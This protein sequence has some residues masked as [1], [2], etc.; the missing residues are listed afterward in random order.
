NP[1]ASGSSS[2]APT[3][4]PS[5]S[6][7]ISGS[8][9]TAEVSPTPSSTPTASGE[10]VPPPQPAPTSPLIDDPSPA[11]ASAQ[12]KLVA[13]FPS[14]LGPPAGTAVESS[15]VSVSSNV[16]Q[17]TLVGQGGDPQQI[18]LHYRDLLTDRGFTEQQLPGADDEPVTAF[19]NGRDIVTV[20][21]Q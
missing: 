14:A 21:T 13:G 3:G 20:T 9:P 8:S 10:P 1:A 5:T 16:L 2:T 7:G 12:G 18:L 6:G 15:S 4:Q 19:V 17:A 11:P